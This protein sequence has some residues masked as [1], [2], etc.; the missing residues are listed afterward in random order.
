MFS[1]GGSETVDLHEIK[2][3]KKANHLGNFCPVGSE[4]HERR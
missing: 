1:L 3:F 2:I 4:E